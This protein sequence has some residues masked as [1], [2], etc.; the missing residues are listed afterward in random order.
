MM[1]GPPKI[2]ECSSC[3]SQVSQP[4]Y[5]SWNTIGS[6][7]WSDGKTEQPMGPNDLALLKCG[8]C[9][10]LVWIDELPIIYDPREA[11]SGSHD[12]NF[13]K[14]LPASDPTFHEYL[15]FLSPGLSDDQ[16]HYVRVHAWWKGNDRRREESQF[17]DL[18]ESETDNLL[19]IVALL[20]EADEYERIMKAEGLRELGGFSTA[21]KLL[22]TKY[23]EELTVIAN[24]LLDLVK[25]KDKALVEV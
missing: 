11:D 17:V 10:S 18:N 25:Q 16:I 13:P 14:A 7:L 8:H 12:N 23:S 3:K 19:A 4:T 1:L 15:K 6:V 20:D 5:L 2:H 21:E 24:F 22:N 9:Q